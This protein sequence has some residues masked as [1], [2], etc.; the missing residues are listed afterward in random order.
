MLSKLFSFKYFFQ[1]PYYPPKFQVGTTFIKVVLPAKLKIKGNNVCKI[2]DIWEDF[3]SF[4][5]GREGSKS[6]EGD[7]EQGFKPTGKE[8]GVQIHYE[9][10]NMLKVTACVEIQ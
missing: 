10:N 6:V 2:R 5:R 9:T 4:G 8:G 3:D 1:L 7:L